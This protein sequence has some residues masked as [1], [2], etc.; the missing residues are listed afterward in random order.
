MALEGDRRDHGIG[1]AI[2]VA[3]VDQVMA[4]AA[5]HGFRPAEFEIAHV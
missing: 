5:R 4:R 3:E 2:D 1:D